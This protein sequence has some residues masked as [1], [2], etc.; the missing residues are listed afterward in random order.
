MRARRCACASSS[1][2][3]RSASARQRSAG[4]VVGQ[5]PMR[6]VRVSAI[7]KPASRAMRMMRSRAVNMPGNAYFTRIFSRVVGP[8]GRVYA[9]LP[10]Q[11]LANC[12]PEERAGTKALETES[13]YANV[14][15]LI[16]AA[17][18]FAVREPLDLVWTAQNYHDL[19]DKFM[20]PIDI[21]RLDAA[22]LRALKPGGTFIVIDHLAAAGAGLRDIETPHRIDAD[23]IITE[24]TAAGF[25]L[26]AHSAPLRNPEDTHALSVFDAAIR[27]HTDQ[28]VLKFRKPLASL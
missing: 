24:V 16:D 8:R 14:R 19:H 3:L 6:N 13:R 1:V 27:Q 26:Q 9:F 23:N 7:V 28:V 2:S 12:K 18:R 11:Q 21:A 10:A 22:I 20:A 15:V 5:N 17:D 4:G 25:V